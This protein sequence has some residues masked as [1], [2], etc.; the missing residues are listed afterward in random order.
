MIIKPSS[1]STF[2]VLSFLLFLSVKVSI[3]SVVGNKWI[4]FAHLRRSN[5][6]DILWRCLC[7]GDFSFLFRLLLM[8]INKFLMDNNNEFV[9][10]CCSLRK[11]K[12]KITDFFFLF[13]RTA[14]FQDLDEHFWKFE[15]NIFSSEFFVDGLKGWNLNG[16]ICE[17]EFE[18]C[19]EKPWFPQVFVDFYRDEPW[20]DV[21]HLVW[22]EYVFLWFQQDKQDHEE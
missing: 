9:F 20:K 19:R 11:T 14:A 5:P 13:C 4:Y 17:D 7:V 10:N 6:Q 15:M 3:P 1:S 16:K 2:F 12:Q 18:W 22:F 21:N 8:L